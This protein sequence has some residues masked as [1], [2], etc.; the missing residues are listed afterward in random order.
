LDNQAQQQIAGNAIAV[1]RTDQVLRRSAPT[2]GIDFILL[3][4]N[5]QESDAK[6]AWGLTRFESDRVYSTWIA[7][8][9]LL[10]LRAAFG[11]GNELPV[12]TALD[13]S[14]A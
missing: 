5:N 10:R 12:Q 9:C 7:S 14:K 8:Y 11:N 2:R 13:E 1:V 6:E 4:R 3:S